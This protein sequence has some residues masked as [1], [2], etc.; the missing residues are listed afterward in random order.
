MFMAAEQVGM[1]TNKDLNAGD[2]IG[3][4][5]GT[6]NCYQGKRITSASAYL[7]NAPSNLTIV[8]GALTAQLLLEG[9]R[10]KGVRTEDDQFF[11]ARSEVV[12]SGGALNSPQ[13]LL[14][15]GIGPREE[16][17]RHNIPVRHELP[18]VGRNLRDHCFSTVGIV[19]KH[20]PHFAET[21]IPPLSP[22]P[23]AFLKS[24]E[25]TSSPDFAQL[26]SEVQK[27]ILAPTV[28]NFE[29]ATVSS[30]PRTRT[31]RW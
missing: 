18:M 3:M 8:T 20:G 22:S 28:P 24:E 14:L 11:F 19:V 7:A 30:E 25:A 21:Q 27:H 5:M 4:G 29:I 1:R 16:L 17:E 12:L 9:E 2:P 13:L 26:P 15:S 10:V 23:M 31:S 6:V